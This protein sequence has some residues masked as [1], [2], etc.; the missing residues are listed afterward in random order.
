MD[1]FLNDVADMLMASGLTVNSRYGHH[2][3]IECIWD[4][5]DLAAE[6][7]IQVLVL[8]D[9]NGHPEFWTRTFANY[10]A[11]YVL[12]IVTRIGDARDEVM[13]RRANARPQ[14]T[15]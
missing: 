15:S 5:A 10:A 9:M 3:T 4:V 6:T 14:M 8:R 11:D 2:A 1:E 13:R 7:V 12:P